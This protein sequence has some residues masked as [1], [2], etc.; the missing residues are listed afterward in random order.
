M[1]G[2]RFVGSSSSGSSSTSNS[3]VKSESV[4]YN[5]PDTIRTQPSESNTK[6]RTKSQSSE[7][8]VR[9]ST[10]KPE[11]SSKIEFASDH[12]A[13]TTNIETNKNS[14]KVLTK[15]PSEPATTTTV[16]DSPSDSPFI[17]LNQTEFT[18]HTSPIVSCR[19]SGNNNRVASLDLGGTFKVWESYPE[20]SQTSI[21]SSKGDIFLCLDWVPNTTD[22]VLVGKANGL[23]SLTD[24]SS[25]RTLWESCVHQKYKRITHVNC[26]PVSTSAV[27]SAVVPISD[28]RKNALPASQ[29]FTNQ[30]KVIRM[31]QYSANT[32]DSISSARQGIISEWD[33]NTGQFKSELCMDPCPVYIHSMGK[34]VSLACM[35]FP[36]SNLKILRVY[37]LI[38]NKSY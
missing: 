3:F 10:Y 26:N 24:V 20:I 32:A 19:F 36:L 30:S 27:C 34:L 37:D 21:Y 11:T 5:I 29:R 17:I 38:S 35:I 4:D 31:K 15:P 2:L 33:L 9:N 8:T 14:E 6:T 28:A 23:L 1:I 22:K 18:E 16:T 13:S 7:A 12:Y 25:K